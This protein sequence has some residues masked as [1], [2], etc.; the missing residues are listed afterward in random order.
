MFTMLEVLYEEKK[1]KE[2]EPIDKIIIYSLFQHQEYHHQKTKKG[3]L[4]TLLKVLFS[5]F[6]QTR[7]YCFV[8]FNVF[9]SLSSICCKMTFQ[10]WTQLFLT[11]YNYYIHKYNIIQYIIFHLHYLKS[12]RQLF[13]NSVHI[14]L[15][16][17]Q[18][19]EKILV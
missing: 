19:V 14:I 17:L 6:P 11:M 7:C 3:L 4:K 13:G 10:K 12:A 16:V 18:I 9:N 5:T 1:L 15:A 2:K 8:R